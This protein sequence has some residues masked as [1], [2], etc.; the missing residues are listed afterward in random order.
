M[1]VDNGF[2]SRDGGVRGDESGYGVIEKFD[3]WI[4]HFQ[5]CQVCKR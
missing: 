1:N 5:F 3:F 2:V 4:G